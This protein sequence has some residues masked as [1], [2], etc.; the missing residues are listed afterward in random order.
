MPQP[1]R[2]L[3]AEASG[4]ASPSSHPS[5]PAAAHLI[6]VGLAPPLDTQAF[7][8]PGL[9]LIRRRNLHVMHG[10]IFLYTDPPSLQVPN[11]GFWGG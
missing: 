8:V 2:S 9:R 5:A 7:P 10:E 4:A 3:T 11:F 1:A 6:A